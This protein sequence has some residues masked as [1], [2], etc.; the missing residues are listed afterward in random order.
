MFSDIVREHYNSYNFYKGIDQIITTLHLTNLF[1]ETLRP[2]ELK[3]SNNKQLLNGCLCITL[4]TL[5]V[6]AILLQP[7]I[8]Q[9]TNQLLT[10]INVSNT[11]R[12]WNSLKPLMWQHYAKQLMYAND[13]TNRMQHQQIPVP[14]SLT[15]D[16]VLLFKRI[17]NQN[18]KN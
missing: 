14:V 12:D 18:K 7:I 2:W 6:C 4:E 11:K 13:E 5:R 17:Q 8:P 16:S 10:K 15:N 3:K 9:L 1:F